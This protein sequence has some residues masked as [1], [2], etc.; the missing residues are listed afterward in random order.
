MKQAHLILGLIGVGGLGYIL[1]RQMANPFAAPNIQYDKNPNIGAQPAQLYPFKP[2]QPPRADYANQPWSAP[3]PSSLAK[4]GPA[5]G[6]PAA[7]SPTMKTA[8][9]LGAAASMVT[10]LTSIWD[11]LGV[12]NWFSGSNPSESVAADLPMQSS[13]NDSV[14]YGFFDWGSLTA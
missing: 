12:G 9:D 3:L 11:D 6:V 8:Q 1:Y 4:S 13:G 14:D 7:L 2:V 10:S 5:P